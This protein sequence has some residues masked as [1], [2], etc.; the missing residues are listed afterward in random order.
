MDDKFGVIMVLALFAVG[1]YLYFVPAIVAHKRKH[2]SFTGILLV[3]LFFG[4]TL[5]GWVGAL[6]WAVTNNNKTVIVQSESTAHDPEKTKECPF[7][8]ETILKA[9]TKCKHCGSAI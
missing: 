2:P 3:D 4:W 5:V 9:A 7:C 8:A 6:V 1:A